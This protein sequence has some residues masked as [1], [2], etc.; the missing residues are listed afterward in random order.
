M[1]LLI[2]FSLLVKIAIAIL[3]EAFYKY[4]YQQLP[5]IFSLFWLH[6]SFLHPRFAYSQYLDHFCTN[7]FLTPNAFFILQHHYLWQK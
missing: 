4:K 2:I 7:I 1:A 3:K 5:V 6:Q